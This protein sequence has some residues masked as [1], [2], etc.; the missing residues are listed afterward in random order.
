MAMRLNSIMKEE[1]EL[2]LMR[3]TMIMTEFYIR[4]DFEVTFKIIFIHS[5][6]YHKP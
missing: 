4:V 2:F 6:S 5:V 1:L 3:K